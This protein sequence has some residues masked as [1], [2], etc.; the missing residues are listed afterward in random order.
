MRAGWITC[1]MLSCMGCVTPIAIVGDE[2]FVGIWCVRA[3][4]PDTAI[5]DQ[6]VAGVGVA[7]SPWAIAAGFLIRHAVRVD[8]S[9]SP[10]GE[11]ETSL[12][13]LLLGP[14]AVGAAASPA[15][16]HRF[17]ERRFRP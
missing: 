2:L 15:R 1:L 9:R 12:V 16:F 7:L 17:L 3:D 6:E 14:K 8:L 5:T 4:E 13:H 11:F 10:Q